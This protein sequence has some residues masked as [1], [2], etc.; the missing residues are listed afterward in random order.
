MVDRDRESQAVVHADIYHGR[1]RSPLELR[2]QIWERIM[3]HLQQA[4]GKQERMRNVMKMMLIGVTV[5][6]RP[7]KTCAEKDLLI[8][9]AKD[10]MDT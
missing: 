10:K 7:T 1:M 2:D 3:G 6:S 8:T 9:Q 5:G 4:Q